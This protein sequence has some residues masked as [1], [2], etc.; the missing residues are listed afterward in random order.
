MR[1]GLGGSG[2]E[3]LH[4]RTTPTTN[5]PP[6]HPAVST[7]GR[8]S[9]GMKECKGFTIEK[10]VGSTFIFNGA[11]PRII[12]NAAIDPSEANRESRERLG[13]YLERFTAFF[14][15]EFVLEKVPGGWGGGSTSTKSPW[16]V[17]QDRRP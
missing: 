3:R 4:P 7:P 17:V 16:S 2:T 1:M 10:T 11:T 8:D 5:Q 6:N 13:P 15:P 9:V 14:T 12:S